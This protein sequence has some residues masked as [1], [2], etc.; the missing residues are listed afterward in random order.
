MVGR[1]CYAL[2]KRRYDI[3]ITRLRHAPLRRL[4]DIPSRRRW[5]FHLRLTCDVA[6]TYRE[7][8]LRRRHDVLMPDGS[9]LHD[10]GILLFVFPSLTNLKLHDISVIPK[11][12]KRVIMNL[13]LSKSS[14][15][16]CILVTV[17]RNC[18]PEIFFIP[19]EIINK[20]LKESWFADCWKVSSVV[21][22]FKN[23]WGR[24]AAKNYHPVS[25]LSMVSE[26]FKKFVNNRIVSSLDKCGLFHIS[27][28][29]SD[30]PD[31]LQIFSQLFLIELP[32]F[33]TGLGLLELWHLLYP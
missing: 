22:V 1:R 4:G 3:P 31:P 2:L 29:V 32:W 23:V 11:M 18:E 12:V 9:N 27:S 20:Y 19:A 30:L 33:L 7:T 21:P 10:S 14:G 8:S 24:P 25:L 17:L 16:D 6:G 13:D 15:P 28:I 26:V 5:V